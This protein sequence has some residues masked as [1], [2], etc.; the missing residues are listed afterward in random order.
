MCVAFLVRLKIDKRR[1]FSCAAMALAMM[2][3]A[4]PWSDVSATG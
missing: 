2:E 4:A 1:V 3:R